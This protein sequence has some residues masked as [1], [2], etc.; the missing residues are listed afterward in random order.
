[1]DSS[2]WIYVIVNTEIKLTIHVLEWWVIAL[3]IYIW[4]HPSNSLLATISAKTAQEWNEHCVPLIIDNLGWCEQLTGVKETPHLFTDIEAMNPSHC[5]HSRMS[6]DEKK[7][8]ILGTWLQ[9]SQF[10]HMCCDALCPVPSADFGISG[11]PCQD[12]SRA[13]LG[14]K[15][16]G[17]TSGVYLTHAKYNLK[18]RTPIFVVE[19]TPEACHHHH[20]S[21]V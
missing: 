1:M 9:E 3:I 8:A 13:G 17:R 4:T 20:E 5:T 21:E 6:Y 16:E 19:C 11:L 15:R 12:M 10:C 14:L 7:G 2:S 18:H